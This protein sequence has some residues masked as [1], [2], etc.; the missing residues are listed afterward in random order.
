MDGYLLT[1][2]ITSI[3]AACISWIWWPVFVLAA[4]TAAVLQ[5]AWCCKMKKQGLIAGAVLA[6]LAFGCALFVGIWMIV[7][8][9]NTIFVV[10]ESAGDDFYYSECS[11][12][13]RNPTAWVVVVFVDAALYLVTAVCT[14]FFVFKRYDAI[15]ARKCAQEQAEQEADEVMVPAVE[16]AVVAS[17][18]AVPDSGDE[19]LKTV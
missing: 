13:L 6:F 19:I 2:Q 8:C 10:I 9:W 3:I 18:M 16:M 17:A 12:Y 5:T 7:E 4:P 14:V 1:A 15:V 11:S